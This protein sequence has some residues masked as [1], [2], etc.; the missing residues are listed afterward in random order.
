MEFRSVELIDSS[1]S[2]DSPAGETVARLLAE[3]LPRYGFQIEG[4]APEDWGW[5]LLV[6]NERFPLWIGCGRYLEYADGHLCFIEPSTRYVRR[7]FRRIP[8]ETVVERLATALEESI[9]QCG[10]A[11]ALR[12]WTDTE[13]G[14]T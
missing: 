4:V 1:E 14:T 9:S 5:R 11:Q 8:T 6:A 10:K 13:I 3:A 12:W 7:W 2:V